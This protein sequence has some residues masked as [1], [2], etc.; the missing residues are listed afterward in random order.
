MK[1]SYL[2]AKDIGDSSADPSTYEGCPGTL[3]NQTC[4]LR[5]AVVD[6]PV[7]LENYEGERPF[8][9]VKLATKDSQY[10]PVLD[11]DPARKQQSGFTVKNLVTLDPEFG[12][13]AVQRLGGLYLAFNTYLG[14]HSNASYD[15]IAGY[16][17]YP[18]GKAQSYV[19]QNFGGQKCGVVYNNPMKP[20]VSKRNVQSI[21]AMINEV[22]FAISMDVSETNPDNK[23]VYADYPAVI[24]TESIHFK[25][26]WLFMV[27]AIMSTVF[28]IICVLPTYWGYWQLGRNVSLGPFEI[29]HAFRSPMT[30]QAGNKPIDQVMDTV[31]HQKVQYGHIVSGDARGVLGVAEP[32]YVAGMP[33]SAKQDFREKI[34][35][36]GATQ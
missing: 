8:Q 13:G 12:I 21:V 15:G 22:M 28:C 3:Y 30:A 11:F 16:S 20:D 29:A 34:L 32:E 9:Q 23:R 7:V 4:T 35:R 19:F 27:G 25:T 17:Q 36:R 2:Q 33:R 18:T 5:P 6:Y 24:Y 14:G 26:R 31:G 10:G 1:I